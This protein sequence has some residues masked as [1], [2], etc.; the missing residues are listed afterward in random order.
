MGH[1]KYLLEKEEVSNKKAKGFTI[2]SL[3]LWET[4]STGKYHIKIVSPLLKIAPKGKKTDARK[5]RPSL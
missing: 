3:A 4:R 2:I 1:L 5:C